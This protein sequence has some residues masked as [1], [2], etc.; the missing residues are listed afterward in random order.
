M[1]ILP[2]VG[3]IDISSVSSYTLTMKDSAH[4][5]LYKTF[6]ELVRLHRERQEGL[7]QEKLGHLVGLSRTSIT[8]IEQGRQHVA[9]HQV[10][11]LADA[12]KVQPE[13]LLPRRGQGVTSSWLA[14]KLPPGTEKEIAAWAEKLSRE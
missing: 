14:E 5:P 3:K 13:A 4:D 2:T 12:L 6:G 8:N 1:S 9:L 10:F 11:D 7:T